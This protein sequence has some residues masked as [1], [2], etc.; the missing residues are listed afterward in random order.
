[1]ASGTFCPLMY[2]RTAWLHP[3]GCPKHHKSWWADW[4]L[5]CHLD[6]WKLSTYS[7]KL[8]SAQ[9]QQPCWGMALQGEESHQQVSPSLIS[10]CGLSTCEER[11]Q[12]PWQSQ[13][14]ELQIWSYWPRR[15]RIR[16]KEKRMQTLFNRSN[17][18][19]LTLNEYLAAI[20]HFTGL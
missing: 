12:W 9:N 17:A 2:A 6:Q 15:R 5:L 14:S 7:L 20:K 8:F 3:I 4:L 19:S 10:L 16:E 1:M 11:K 13:N 18:G